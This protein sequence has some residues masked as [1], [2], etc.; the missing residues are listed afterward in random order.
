[1]IYGGG[2]SVRN[3]AAA[4]DGLAVYLCIPF[5]E[6]VPNARTGRFYLHCSTQL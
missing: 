6:G 4:M 5:R 1:M 2:K 3:A